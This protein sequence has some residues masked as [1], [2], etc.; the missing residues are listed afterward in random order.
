MEKRNSCLVEMVKQTCNQW[1]RNEG[2][3]FMVESL[4]SLQREELKLMCGSVA[5]VLQKEVREDCLT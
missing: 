5:V 3:W 2:L 1:K 4:Q